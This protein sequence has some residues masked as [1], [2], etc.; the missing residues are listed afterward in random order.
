MKSSVIFLPLLMLFAKPS[1]GQFK[2]TFAPNGNPTTQI[3][4]A[5]GMKQGHWNYYDA[6]DHLFR[7]ETYTDHVL[8]KS[9]YLLNGTEIDLMGYQELQLSQLN[10]Q[11][12]DLITKKLQPAGK[13]ELVILQDGSVHL[14]FYLDKA[15]GKAPADINLDPVKQLT[16]T[17]SIIKF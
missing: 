17:R 3:I 10:A 1:F 5:S 7:I 14:H 13:G 4:D 2:N 11:A 8:T 12:I 6:D 16:L 9:V 15:K